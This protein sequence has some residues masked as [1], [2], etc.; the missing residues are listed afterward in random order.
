[1]RPHPFLTASTEIDGDWY[2]GCHRLTPNLEPRPLVAGIEVLRTRLCV[3][4][5][6]EVL[7]RNTHR[8][9]DLAR[10]WR[11]TLYTHTTD[12]RIGPYPAERGCGYRRPA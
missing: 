7:L 5:L 1:M 9:G 8:C 3:S 11:W 6:S 10:S 4:E 2:G 12:S